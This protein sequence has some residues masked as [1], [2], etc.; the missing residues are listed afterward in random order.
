MEFSLQA[1]PRGWGNQVIA[2]QEAKTERNRLGKVLGR[3]PH[4]IRLQGKGG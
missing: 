1:K 3:R 4:H 2:D